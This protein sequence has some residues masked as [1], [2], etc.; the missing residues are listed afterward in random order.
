MVATSDGKRFRSKRV[1]VKDLVEHARAG[2]RMRKFRPLTAGRRRAAHSHGRR[3]RR[4]RRELRTPRHDAGVPTV[5]RAM[6][7]VEGSGVR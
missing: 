7:A 6:L 1:R 5:G 3:E 4:F 2:R